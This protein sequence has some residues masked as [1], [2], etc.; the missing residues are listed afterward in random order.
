MVDTYDNYDTYIQ[1]KGTDLTD[2]EII[3]PVNDERVSV[4]K[5]ACI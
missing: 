3:D 2:K 4:G 1:T 5:H